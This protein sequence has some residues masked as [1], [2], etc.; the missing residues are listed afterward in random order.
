[1]ANFK[2]DL[3]QSQFCIVQFSSLKMYFEH[4]FG[5]HMPGRHGFATESGD[6]HGSY[7]Y[8]LP[9]YLAVN[10]RSNNTPPEYTAR[11]QVALDNGFSTGASS[12]NYVVYI[13]DSAM[14]ATVDSAYQLVANGYRYGFNGQEHDVDNGNG[15][16]S[17]TALFWEYDSRSGRRWNIDPV[18]KSS[19]SNYVVLGNNPISYVDPLGDN[20]FKNKNGGYDW[21]DKKGGK[22]N[23]WAQGDKKGISVWYGSKNNDIMMSGQL[24]EVIVTSSKKAPRQDPI[25]AAFANSMSDFNHSAAEEAAWKVS[26][27]NFRKGN[28]SSISPSQLKLYQTLEGPK[29]GIGKSEI[30]FLL[31]NLEVHNKLMKK[32][33]PTIMK[34][35]M[36][37]TKNTPFFSLYVLEKINK[38]ESV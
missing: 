34:P 21:K 26:Q 32:E 30:E 24:D 16:D 10:F 11:I 38:K 15:M 2:F 9:D 37:R 28:F 20:W 1:M 27:D 23:F 4:P 35:K 5:M 25:R 18:P 14:Q 3:F 31:R 8:Y 19:V 22:T 12:D 17:Y 6:W 13:I 36:I 7:G 29:L 33:Y